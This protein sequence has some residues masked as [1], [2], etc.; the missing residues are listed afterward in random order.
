MNGSLGMPGTSASAIAAP[1]AMSS[2]VRHWVSCLL[3][4]VPMSASAV[5]RVTIRPVETDISSA[6]IW[7]TRPSPMVS[8]LNRLIASPALM[9]ICSMP[10]A[11]PPSRLMTVM[12]MPAI[13]SPLTNFEPPSMAP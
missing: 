9:P 8:R 4:A 7:V 5:A 12:M 10:T 6:G 11:N 2:A 13:A 1:P 3:A